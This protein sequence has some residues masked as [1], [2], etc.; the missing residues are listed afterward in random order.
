[1]KIAKHRQKVFLT[2]GN[3]MLGRN[4]L[5]H[6]LSA[7]WDFFAPDR[8]ELD[9][10]NFNLLVEYIDNIKPD[11]IIHAAGH[12]GGINASVQNPVDFLV[13]NLD[14]GRNVV[15]AAHQTRIKKLLNI[16][17]SCM[18]PR[19]APNPL[20][21]DM[22]L[23]GELEC[24]NEGYALAKIVTQRLCEYIHTEN[25]KYQYKTMIPCNL[26]GCFDKFEL[27]RAHLIPAIINKMH[28]I[29]KEEKTECEI[30]GDGKSRREFMYAGDF[31]DAI[32]Y[33]LDNFDNMPSLLN[34][35]TGID[36]TINEY[37]SIVA[38]LMNYQ[39][40]FCYNL[41]KPAGMNQKLVSIEKQ[42]KWGWESTT[43]IEEGIKR[44]YNCY[45]QG[46]IYKDGVKTKR[47]Q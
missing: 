5:C 41:D 29:I 31:S 39:G 23:K 33:A 11:Y 26:Y 36:Y 6:P 38:N 1:M 9:L 14:L 17:S 7:K 4:I 2:G 27:Y 21:E 45:L 3:G 37:Y 20:K 32:L 10:T 19:N 25:N 47:N 24:T 46:Q 8:K 44:T 43:N 13:S 16:G 12:I 30:W 40:N 34:I 35:G 15:L 18:Y 28:H 42:I 22:I